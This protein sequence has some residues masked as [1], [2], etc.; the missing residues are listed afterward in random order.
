M[1]LTIPSSPTITTILIYPTET[2]MPRFSADG[3]Y[4]LFNNR[5]PIST[6]F[7]FN[8]AVFLTNPTIE[9]LQNLEIPV[10]VDMLAYQ[11]GLH[12]QLLKTE[13]MS[14]ATDACKELITNIQVVIETKR[15]LEQNATNTS[16]GRSYTQDITPVDPPQN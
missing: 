16:A 11:T 14:S 7:E 6:D 15:I 3:P 5:K 4:T 13:G 12:L 2:S 8:I 10:L 1:L 9:E